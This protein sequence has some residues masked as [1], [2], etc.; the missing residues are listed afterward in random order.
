MKL[1]TL[2]L[3]SLLMAVNA[4]ALTLLNSYTTTDGARVGG[5]EILA[6]T[7]DMNTLLSTVGDNTGGSFGVQVLTMGANSSLTERG[8]VDLSG[9]FGASA[10]W[11]GAS[12]VS[13]DPL[14]RG[15]GAVTLIPSANTTTAG[16]VAFFDYRNPT[17]LVTVD[18]GFHPDSLKF[19]ADGTKLFVVNEG[20]FNDSVANPATTGNAP[21][22]ISI[23]DLSGVSSLADVNATNITSGSVSTFDFSSANLDTGVTLQ[24]IRN[25][26]IA[27]VPTGTSGGSNTLVPDF[28]SVAVYGDADFYKG[29]EPEYLTQIGDK[30]HVSLQENNAIATFDLATNK[31]T[32]INNLGTITQTIDASDQDGGANIN[33]VVKGLPMPDTIAGFT[34]GGVNYIVTANEGDA[35]IDDGDVNRLGDTGGANSMNN[36]LDT[37][38]VFPTTATGIRDNVTGLG[39]LNVSRIDGDTGANGGVAGDGKID[40]AI[41]IGTRSFSIWNA[42]TGA[43]VWDSGSLESVLLALDPAFHNNNQNSFGTAPNTDSRSDDKG[44]EPEALT[45]AQ[46]G[47][48]TLAFIGLERQGGVLVY[49]ITNPNNPVQVDYFSAGTNYAE[50]LVGPESMVFISAADSPTGGAL[51]VSGFEITNGIAVYGV[52][53]P[54]R[55]MLGLA[56]LLLIAFRRRRN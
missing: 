31:W 56:G 26:S 33:D 39:R 12:S 55:A 4:E 54:S 46:F 20:E 51:L 14:G 6:F 37:T 13:V 2:T 41:M 15:W 9:T 24:G 22:S 29:L 30:L 44:P 27:A 21:G 17:A 48:Q 50:G 43:L 23:I 32:A 8:F 52:P 35:R 10:N 38:N 25:P 40:E 53:E 42:D 3:A 34:S 36:V 11:N 18:V 28:N 19:S 5:A 1:K 49:D 47:S 16:K 7:P 45:V